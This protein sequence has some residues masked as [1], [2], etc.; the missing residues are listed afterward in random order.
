MRVHMGQASVALASLLPKDASQEGLALPGADGQGRSG[1]VVSRGG[2]SQRMKMAL[3]NRVLRKLPIVAPALRDSQ[4]WAFRE[5]ARSC[6]A[7]LYHEPNFIAMPFEGPIVV[8]VHDLSVLR[9]PETHPA[10]RVRYMSDNMGE[11]LHR[12][13]RIVTVSE[14]VR[15]EVLEV[16]GS[17]MAPKTVAIHNG[18][19]EHFRPRPEAALEPVLRRYDL[20]YGQYL[21]ALGTLEPRK[22]LVRLLKAYRLAGPLPPLVL[23]GDS[24]WEGQAL[25]DA[26]HA[27]RDLPIRVLGYLPQEDLP[28]VVAGARVMAYPSVYEGFGLP[29]VEA[30]A[31]GVP[32]LSSKASA[33]TEVLDGA[34]LQAEAQDIDAMAEGLRQLHEDEALRRDLVARGLVR[35]RAF[36]WQKTGAQLSALYSHLSP[37]HWPA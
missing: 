20:A 25:R 17:V 10:E 31:S 34:G 6:G 37:K 23:V 12:A 9:H 30:M 27:Y 32:V 22:N 5:S 16:F 4:K 7:G 15:R 1:E 21:L 18:V 35:A 36:S 11:S 3:W 13:D 28:L 19:T 33:L 14:F 29:L 24:G 26:L 2:L 8:T